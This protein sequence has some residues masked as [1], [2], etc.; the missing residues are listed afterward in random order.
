MKYN[1]CTTYQQLVKIASICQLHLMKVTK[2]IKKGLTD[3]KQGLN[4]GS[5]HMRTFRK[6]FLDK[7]SIKE[8]RLTV[9]KKN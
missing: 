1:F 3:K 5:L 8:V 9:R 6:T 2:D 7:M 4:K